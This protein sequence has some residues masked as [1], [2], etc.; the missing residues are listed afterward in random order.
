MERIF[1]FLQ[2]V[3]SVML[4]AKDDPTIFKDAD[5][6]RYYAYAVGGDG[7]WDVRIQNG[8]DWVLFDPVYRWPQFVSVAYKLLFNKW[9]QGDADACRQSVTFYSDDSEEELRR[10]IL[11]L[12]Q[13]ICLT[14]QIVC[15]KIEELDHPELFKTIKRWEWWCAERNNFLR[16]AQDKAFLRSEMEDYSKETSHYNDQWEFVGDKK[17]PFWTEHAFAYAKYMLK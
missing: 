4:H 1:A 7:I 15:S 14:W 5:F 9:L 12:E 16:S 17:A 3:F 13:T 11:Y 2:Y 10:K 6:G 8:R